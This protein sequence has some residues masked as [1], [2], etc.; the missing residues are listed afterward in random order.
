VRASRRFVVG[1][2]VLEP[3]ADV[4]N[5]FDEDNRCCVESFDILPTADGGSEVRPRYNA[6]LPRAVS[7]GLHWRF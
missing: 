3:F 6:G 4:A 2:H 1:R 7:A 5:V